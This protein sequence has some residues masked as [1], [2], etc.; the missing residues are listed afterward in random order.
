M[1]SKDG[2]VPLGMLNPEDGIAFVLR[3]VS[4]Y[5]VLHPRRLEST[6]SNVS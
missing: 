1:W 4:N 5:T 3:N 6:L 2:L